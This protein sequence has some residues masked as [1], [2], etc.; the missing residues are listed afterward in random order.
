MNMKTCCEEARREMTQAQSVMLS[1]SPI[2]NLYR[3]AE[4]SR[5][6]AQTHLDKCAEPRRRRMAER[7]TKKINGV[8]K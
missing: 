5:D 1:F 7:I 4:I 6:A 3:G 8:G 2:N